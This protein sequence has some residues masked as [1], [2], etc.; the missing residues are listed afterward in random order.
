[1]ELQITSLE[2]DIKAKGGSDLE[3][4]AQATATPE[5]IQHQKK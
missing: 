3:I 2:Q 5:S 1:M 4:Q